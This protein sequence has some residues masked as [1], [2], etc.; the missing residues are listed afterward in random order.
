MDGR[1]NRRNKAAFSY[2]SGVV[3]TRPE[4][5]SVNVCGKKCYDARLI[6]LSSFLSVNPQVF[7]EGIQ[8]QYF[9][10]LFV[11]RTT[12]YSVYLRTKQ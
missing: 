4:L 11:L 3:S 8:R 2:F 5:R 12:E 10:Y 9:I 7:S 1:P 6:F